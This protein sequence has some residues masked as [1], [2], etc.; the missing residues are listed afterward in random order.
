MNWVRSNGSPAQI[1]EGH[2]QAGAAGEE[3]SIGDRN[4]GMDVVMARAMR[5]VRMIVVVAVK[6]SCVL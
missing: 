2:G 6:V 1:E 4:E 3:A 5:C